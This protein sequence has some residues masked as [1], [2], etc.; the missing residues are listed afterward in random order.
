M[1]RLYAYLVSSLGIVSCIAQCSP[2]LAIEA[3][4]EPSSAIVTLDD[5]AQV[6]S[7]SQLSDVKPTDWAFQ[8]LQSLVERYGCIVGYPDKTYRGNRALTRYEFAAGLNACLDKIQE[9]IAAATADFVKKEDLETVKKLQ[10]EFAA[11]LATLRG[12]VDA[13]ET[14]TATLEK[15]QFSTTTKLSGQVIFAINGGTQ[16][17]ATDPSIT[18]FHRTRLNLETSFSGKDA[19]LT[20]LQAGNGNSS[21]AAGFFQ[22]ENGNFRNRLV[23]IGEAQIQQQFERIFFP[24]NELD[25]TLEDLG[26]G[27]ANL[28]TVE[29]V[30]DAYAGIIR[31]LSLEEGVSPET[32]LSLGNTL[33]RGIETGRIINRFLQAN[34]ALDYANNITPGL[35]VNRLSYTF[36]VGKDVQISL[37]PQGHLSDYVDRNPYANN[38]ATNF[39]T[40][41]LINNQLLLAGDIP[42][43]GAAFSWNPGQGAFTLRAA[44]RAEQVAFVNTGSIF[45]ESG[46]RNGIFNSPNLG[47][48]ELEIAPSKTVALRLQYSR[49]TQAGSD[50]S[51]LGANF[52]LALG[53]HLGL[54]GRF[55]Y[56]L[57]F[58]GNIQAIA[59]SAGLAFPDLLGKGNLAGISV[60]QPLRLQDD[61]LGLFNGTQTNYE[62]FY[63]IQ[64]S[65]N[66]AISPILQVITNPGNA[67]ADTVFTATLRTL[68][69][70]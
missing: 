23:G 9:L 54:F 15:Q 47:V 31:T 17:N 61:V 19:L 7:V 30:R 1:N 21:D 62:A 37:F 6:T 52:D 68:F 67:K 53:K 51:A 38:S 3:P 4:A 26:I 70:F 2:A 64:V 20:Q 48:V 69:S 50:Y 56:A 11:E 25:L 14:R 36:P 66:I 28:K 49:G 45:G 42:G 24:L 18:F 12:Q 46:D 34:S 59:W 29:E 33:I 58:P 39:S 27:L 16:A 13:L 55:G 43:A 57:D 44:Y 5:E 60:G 65:D 41:G 63:R 35:N 32:A 22:Q 10:E 40:Y 8:A